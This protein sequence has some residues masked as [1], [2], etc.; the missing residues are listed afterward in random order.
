V[1]YSPFLS[2]FLF[3]TGEATWVVSASSTVLIEDQVYLVGDE[4]INITVPAIYESN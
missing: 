4:A 1:T 3:D 2:S